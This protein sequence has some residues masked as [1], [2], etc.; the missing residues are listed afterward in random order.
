MFAFLLSLT[1]GALL[2]AEGDTAPKRRYPISNS[3]RPFTLPS[4]I[5][6]IDLLATHTSAS[7]LGASIL[8]SYGITDNFQVNA[9]YDGV[10]LLDFE[11]V[12]AEQS[13][14]VGFDYFLFESRFV[15]S[16]VDFDFPLYVN[17]NVAQNLKLALPTS[18]PLWR[19]AKLGLTILNSGLVDFI[20]VPYVGADINLP[21]RIGW[22]AT[23]GLSL[24]LGTNL[25]TFN[26]N[27]PD[28]NGGYLGN[29]YI[30]TVT[31]LYLHALYGFQ[32]SFDLNARIG[33]H[34]LQR[35]VGNNFY[36]WFGI[37]VRFGK[38]TS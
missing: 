37:N 36:V 30:W 29:A 19:A 13:F 11:T 15:S 17:N 21:A 7:S 28:G 20:F 18:I 25:A 24:G 5:A 3:D 14:H 8:T 4:E 35:N 10:A 2:Y 26:I 31:P 22:Q 6:E 27:K 16:M 33:F 34:D 23:E 12:E 1:T 9:G 32:D 38:M